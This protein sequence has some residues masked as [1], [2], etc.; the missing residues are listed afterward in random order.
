[1]TEDTVPEYIYYEHHGKM[2]WVRKDLKG[3]HRDHCLCH[4]CGRFKPDSQ[5]KCKIADHLFTFCKLTG[6]VTPMW[7]CE[8]FEPDTPIAQ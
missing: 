2:V 4:K 1:M 7:E 5:D 8:F 3:K 6:C